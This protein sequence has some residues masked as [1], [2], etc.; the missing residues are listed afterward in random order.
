MWRSA[1]GA[2]WNRRT[3][4]K[5]SDLKA[6]P[7]IWIREL[8]ERTRPRHMT[9]KNIYRQLLGDGEEIGLATIYRVLTQFESAG[10]VLRAHNFG[11]AMRS[12]NS[13]AASTTT[14]WSTS[15][16]AR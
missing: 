12:T 1:H 14:T 16:A 4:A 9:A 13:T 10:L 15:T 2:Q 5:E 7:R 3:C 6:H 8:L 11:A